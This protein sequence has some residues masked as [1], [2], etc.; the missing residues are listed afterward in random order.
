MVTWSAGRFLG[1][2]KFIIVR[3]ATSARKSAER[4]SEE[5]LPAAQTTSATESADWK[6]KISI[7]CAH[8]LNL[9]SIEDRIKTEEKTKVV[10][11]V[12][13]TYIIG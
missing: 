6:E 9:L 2:S 11:A 7:S 1:N 12:W 13:G 3:L 8:I 10:A 4:R 5:F